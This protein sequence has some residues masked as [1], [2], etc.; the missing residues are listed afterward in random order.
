MKPVYFGLKTRRSVRCDT[1]LCCPKEN[2]VAAVQLLF[3][4]LPLAVLTRPPFSDVKIYKDMHGVHFVTCV[5]KQSV[6]FPFKIQGEK[7]FCRHNVHKRSQ[8]P[9]VPAKNRCYMVRFFFPSVIW[10]RAYCIWKNVHVGRG[11]QTLTCRLASV[12][13]DLLLNQLMEDRNY[14]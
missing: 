10:N 14:F 11:L 13:S 7:H 9:S 3:L 4:G 2:C 12:I 5:H 1:S 6:S 8:T